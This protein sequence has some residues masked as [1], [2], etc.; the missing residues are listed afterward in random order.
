MKKGKR[1][2][3]NV[4]HRFKKIVYLSIGGL[5]FIFLILT[6]TFTIYNNRLK[7]YNYSSL[8]TDKIADLVP[9]IAEEVRSD[10]IQ[11]AS[12]PIG[13]TIEQVVENEKIEEETNKKILEENDEQENIQVTQ[14]DI[15]KDPEFINPVEGEILRGYAKDSLI[16][17]DTLEEWIVHLGIDIKAERTTVVKAAECGTI[18]SIKDD[19]RYGLTIR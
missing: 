15:V 7:K 8:S 9:N 12:N 13:K 4:R 1:E 11:E 19:P 2:K 10:D 17:S 3:I 16:Y 5:V 6:I 14:E 18:I